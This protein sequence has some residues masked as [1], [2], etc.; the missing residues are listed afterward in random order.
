LRSCTASAN[1]ISTL[2]NY[3]ARQQIGTPFSR[4]PI[5]AGALTID[6]ENYSGGLLA[7][8]TLCSRW[9]TGCRLAL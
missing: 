5:L 4:G 2:L 3:I 9:P 8:T 1:D 6:R 7:D